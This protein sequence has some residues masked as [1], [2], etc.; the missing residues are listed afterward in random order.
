MFDGKIPESLIEKI[1]LNNKLLNKS[2]NLNKWYRVFGRGIIAGLGA[3]I[4][5]AI[6]VST[7][8]YILNRIEFNPAL[9]GFIEQTKILLEKGKY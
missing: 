3:T 8:A 9:G 4:G 7:L 2:I 5:L 6:V 1:D